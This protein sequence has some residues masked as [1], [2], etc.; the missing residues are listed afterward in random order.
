VLINAFGLLASRSR[1]PLMAGM[2]NSYDVTCVREKLSDC[3]TTEFVEVVRETEQAWIA[4]AWTL[5][6]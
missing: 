6:S 5:K 4:P 2:T 1:A 3:C